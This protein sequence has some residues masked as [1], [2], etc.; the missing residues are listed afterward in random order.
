MKNLKGSAMVGAM[1]GFN[2]H[3]A[4]IVFNVFIATSQDLAQNVESSHYISMMEAINSDKD[5]HISVTIPCIEF[6]GRLH[7]PFG[8]LDTW[9]NSTNYCDWKGIKCDNVTRHLIR[10]D[11]RNPGGYNPASALNNLTDKAF[12]LFYTTD[13]LPSEIYDGI[14][15][16]LI[17]LQM[18]QHLDLSYNAFIDVR[19]PW[20]LHRLRNL[21]YLNLSNAG[22]F[23]EIPRDLVNIVDT[24]SLVYNW[25]F[26]PILRLYLS[27]SL[28]YMR[29]GY[30]T[31]S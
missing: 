2:V 4:N 22:F 9:N 25:I 13:V 3:I 7:G 27:I 17:R 11:H 28:D 23:R 26:L 20:K 8:R 12:S 19:M 24:Y 6:K 31:L 5:L 16:L 15:S 10:L 14:L 29:I 18:L 1:G 30:T 21:Q